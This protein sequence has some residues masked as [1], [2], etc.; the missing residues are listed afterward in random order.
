MVNALQS[1]SAHFT[2]QHGILAEASMQLSYTDANKYPS[3]EAL[4]ASCHGDGNGEQGQQEVLSLF[5]TLAEQI[6]VG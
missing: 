5:H 6:H 1:I 2:A 3:L 4:L